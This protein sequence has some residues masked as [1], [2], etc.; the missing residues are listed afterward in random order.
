MSVY[1]CEP[2]IENPV[3]KKQHQLEYRSFLRGFSLKEKNEPSDQ[4]AN[5]RK[6]THGVILLPRLIRYWSVIFYRLCSFFFTPQLMVHRTFYENVHIQT[7]IHIHI[8]IYTQNLY[9]LCLGYIVKRWEKKSPK[10]KR[11]IQTTFIHRGYFSPFQW[12]KPTSQDRRMEE[13]KI[14]RITY[15][16]HQSERIHANKIIKS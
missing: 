11:T 7:Y 5:D 4:P 8:Y 9:I 2:F 1:A 10:K 12:P 16:S 15:T 6:K 14:V 13:P 3:V